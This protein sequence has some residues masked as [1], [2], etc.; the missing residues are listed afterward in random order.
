MDRKL[1]FNGLRTPDGTQLISRSKDH[2]VIHYDKVTKRT[3][4]LDGGLDHVRSSA[5]GDEVFQTVY[6]DEP[7]EKVREFA[8]KFNRFLDNWITLKDIT[9][10]WLENI[11]EDYIRKPRYFNMSNDWKLLFLQEKQ[12][13]NEQEFCV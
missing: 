12:Y 8:Y 4:M 9:D 3:Y 5:W 10:D 11:I 1:V 2:C 13:R 6:M 7:F